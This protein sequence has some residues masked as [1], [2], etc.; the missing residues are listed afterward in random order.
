MNHSAKPKLLKTP[1]IF[2]GLVGISASIYFLCDSCQTKGYNFYNGSTID[3][4]LVN[5][6]KINHKEYHLIL[7]PNNG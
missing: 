2:A 3:D 6:N 1:L 5:D 4:S 7:A